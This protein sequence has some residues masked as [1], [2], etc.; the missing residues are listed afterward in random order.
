MCG[1]CMCVCMCV[2]PLVLVCI[3]IIHSGVLTD[4]EDKGWCLVSFSIALHL[5]WNKVSLNLGFTTSA[6]LPGQ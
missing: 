1:M 4:V 2:C 5:S 3:F 6:K